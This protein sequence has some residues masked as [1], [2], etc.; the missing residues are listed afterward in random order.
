M[1]SIEA[2]RDL[3]YREENDLLLDTYR[4]A[5]RVKNAGVQIDEA[6]FSHLSNYLEKD[7][8]AWLYDAVK[9]DYSTCKDV[10][11]MSKINLELIRSVFSHPAQCPTGVSFHKFT[12]SFNLKVN[13]P[14]KL[15][16]YFKVRKFNFHFWQNGFDVSCISQGANQDFGHCELNTMGMQFSCDSFLERKRCAYFGSEAAFFEYVNDVLNK[17]G[18][19][20]SEGKSF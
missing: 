5:R 2:V 11:G 20:N 16:M 7:I 17:P 4:I 8:P 9:F 10:M 19:F 18:Y 3:I 13:A 14:E 15:Y 6:A 12:G 1:I